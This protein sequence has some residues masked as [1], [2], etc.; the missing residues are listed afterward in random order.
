MVYFSLEINPI[1]FFCSA[2]T[3]AELEYNSNFQFPPPLKIAEVYLPNV[4]YLILVNSIEA[5]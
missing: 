1:C 4:T 2:S 5:S 3:A